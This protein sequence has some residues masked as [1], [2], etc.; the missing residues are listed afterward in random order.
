MRDLRESIRIDEFERND[1]GY[2]PR[3]DDPCVCGSGRRARSCHRAADLSWVANPLPPLL[4]DERTGYAHPSC[5]G[6]VSNDCSRDLSREHYITEDIL[7]QIRHEDTG[8]TIGG[9]TWVPRGEARTV[10][11]GALASR[12]LCRRHNNALSPLDK[13]A[14]HFFRAL[15]ADQLSLVA[16]YGPDG[17]FPCSF[18]LV[19]GQAIELWLLKVI[20]GVLSTE[21]MPLADGSPAYRF[22]LRY[23]RS[24]LAEILWRG[25]PWPSGA[26]MYL[27]PPRTTAEGVKTRSIAVRVLQDGPEC[28]GGIVRCAGIEFAV[29]LERPANRAIYRP[30]AIHFDRAGFQ[31]WKALGFAWPEMGHLPWR[32]SSQ[33][34][35]GEDVHTPPWQ[36]DR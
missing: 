18:T 12:I 10:G 21:T 29:L 35:R 33:L 20:W 7:E 25:E 16:D 14:S 28:F 13:I 3:P 27:A 31:N 24:Q 15:V 5:Y 4:T 36:R 26:G 11:V 32:F 1:W 8:V 6:N 2:G 19:H 34:A 17:E 30:A 22:G 23:P 9:T